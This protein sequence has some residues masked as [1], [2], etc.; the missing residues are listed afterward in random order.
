MWKDFKRFVTRG[1]L[2]DLAI[3]VVIGTAFAA[4]TKSFVDDIVMPPLGLLTGDIDFANMFVLLKEG[5]PAGPLIAPP[6]CRS[7]MTR[8]DHRR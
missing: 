3:G 4:V 1:K 8:H 2:I 6:S 5:K 7:T